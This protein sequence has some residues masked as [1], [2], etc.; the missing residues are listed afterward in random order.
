MRR[1]FRQ[2]S[3]FPEERRRAV[4]KELVRLR[5]MPPERR[6]ARLK[7]ERFQEQFSETEREFLDKLTGLLTRPASPPRP[8]WPRYDAQAR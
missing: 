7:S 6:I 4:R 2:L 5:N 1:L 8:D 3:D